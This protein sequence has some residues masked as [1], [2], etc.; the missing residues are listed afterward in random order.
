MRPRKLEKKDRQ[1]RRNATQAINEKKRGH[2]ADAAA[3]E[4]Q[5]ENA[6][7]QG[8]EEKWK[9]SD[10]KSSRRLSRAL[11]ALWALAGSRGDGEKRRGRG[12]EEEEKR[13]RKRS[14]GKGM[15]VLVDIKV[16]SASGR[17]L[18]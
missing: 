10:D 6:R 15:E 13:K 14:E 16:P 1:K 8:S 7:K 11:W 9:G 3:E 5:R 4:M 18:P 17:F 2:S 12:N